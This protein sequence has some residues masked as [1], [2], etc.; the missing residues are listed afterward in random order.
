MYVHLHLFGFFIHSK[1]LFIPLLVIILSSLILGILLF[2]FVKIYSKLIIS[3]ILLKVSYLLA[4]VLVSILF[5]V[6]LVS[7][8]KPFSYASLKLE[9]LKND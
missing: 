7:F 3:N 9:F 4:V 8:Y 2:L 1:K 5:Y 6:M